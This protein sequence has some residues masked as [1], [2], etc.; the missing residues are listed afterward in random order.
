MQPELQPVQAEGYP[1]IISAKSVPVASDPAEPA[2]IND[3]T[4]MQ[5]EIQAKGHISI[6]FRCHHFQLQ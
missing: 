3:E 6:Q 4:E 5:L 1:D 2:P